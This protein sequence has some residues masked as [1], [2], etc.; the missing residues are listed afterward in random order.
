MKKKK[1]FSTANMTKEQV[2]RL[3]K[4]NAKKIINQTDKLRSWGKSG[5]WK[6]PRMNKY[7]HFRSMLE[8]NTLKALEKDL[9]IKEYATEQFIISYNF[10]GAMLNYVPDIVLKT[11]KGNVF[12]VEVKPQ[13]QFED[14]KNVAKWNEAKEWCFSRG[15]KFIVVCEKDS[16][17]ICEIVKAYEAND[18]PKVHKLM[19]WKMFHK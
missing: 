4:S 3:S 19:E 14:E 12:V 9:Y 1:K 16:Q 17:N 6:S 13:S 8:A 18:I 5:F 7:F 15:A 10:K 2:E 11:E